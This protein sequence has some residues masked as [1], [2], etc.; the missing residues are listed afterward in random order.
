MTGL[1][2]VALVFAGLVAVC[3][4]WFRAARRLDRGWSDWTLQPGE[5]H[6]DG[7]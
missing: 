5:F 4:W 1:F 2:L 7:E 6:E 3:V